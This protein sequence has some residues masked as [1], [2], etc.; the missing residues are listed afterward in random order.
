MKPALLLIVLLISTPITPKTHTIPNESTNWRIGLA[1][2]V[3]QLIPD[4]AIRNRLLSNQYIISTY[5][6]EP[7]HW[8]NTQSHTSK[9][10]LENVQYC[11]YA[12]IDAM[13]KNNW[14]LISMRFGVLSHWIG[15]CADPFCTANDTSEENYEIYQEFLQLWSE[16]IYSDILEK[17]GSMELKEAEN[18]SKS[19]IRLIEKAEQKY[20]PIISAIDKND[21][22]LLLSY[23]SE[24]AEEAVKTLYGL[25]IKAIKNS[26][27]A[28]SMRVLERWRWVAISMIL[29]S[30]I[31]IIG[32]EI[33]KRLT[34]RL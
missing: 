12:L 14:T 2:T 30:I 15:D 13:N 1:L 24:L 31:V 23:A 7:S 27:L 21:T 34:R 26:D 25:V 3:A 9:Y 6:E 18:I 19:A 33:R 28:T 16:D 22:A 5:A 4:D 29:L 8:N 17:S 20:E 10:L 32:S 11:Y